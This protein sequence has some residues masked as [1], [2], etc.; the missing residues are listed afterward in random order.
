MALIFSLMSKFGLYAPKVETS[1]AF[2]LRLTRLQSRESRHQTKG[3]IFVRS[4]A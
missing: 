4:Q 3:A 2:D 1:E